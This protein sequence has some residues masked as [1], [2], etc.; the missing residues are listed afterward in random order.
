MGLCEVPSPSQPD[1]SVRG[2]SGVA[3]NI[4]RVRAQVLVWDH[5]PFLARPHQQLAYPFTKS[6]SLQIESVQQ[7]VLFEAGAAL[8]KPR[9]ILHDMFVAT[10]RVSVTENEDGEKS[11]N[12]VYDFVGSIESGVGSVAKS[13][14]PESV[15]GD[16]FE[17]KCNGRKAKRTITLIPPSTK[18]E[19]TDEIENPRIG[20]DIFP[21]Q[22]W[23]HFGSLFRQGVPLHPSEYKKSMSALE[24]LLTFTALALLGAPAD[25]CPRVGWNLSDLQ[26][27][28]KWDYNTI[29]D[30]DGTF[31]VV[32]P[33]QIMKPAENSATP[34]HWSLE[35]LTPTWQGEDFIV[36]V[37][38]GDKEHPT[39]EDKNPETDCVDTTWDDYKY[40][41]YRLKNP[42]AGWVDGIS[43]AAFYIEDKKEET[44]GSTTSGA[45]GTG[46]QQANEENVDVR[47]QVYWWKYKTYIL[48]EIGAGHNFH[49]YFIEIVKGRNPR[50]LHIGHVWDNPKR[51]QAGAEGL[52]PND[53]TW[54]RQC[55]V[56]SEYDNVS[57]DEL[58]KK[59]DFRFTVRNHLGKMVITFEGYE[60]DPWV[61]TRLDN[62]PSRFNFTQILVPMIVPPAKMRMHGG[63]ISAT[64]NWSPLEYTSTAVIPY[65]DRQ[66]DTGEANNNDLYMT[67]SHMGVSIQNQNTAVKRRFFSEKRLG[68]GKIGYDCDAFTVIECNKNAFKN[69]NLYD[70]YNR[71]FRLYGKGWVS[72]KPVAGTSEQG[73]VGLEKPH[74]LIS[75]LI[76]PHVLEILNLRGRNRSSSAPFRFGL[77]EQSDSSYPYKEFVSRWDVGIRLSAGSVL[78][79][80]LSNEEANLDPGVTTSPKLFKNYVTPIA[81]QWRMIVLGGGKPIQD[82]VDVID[83]SDLIASINDSWNAEGFTTINH[84]MEVEAYIP[85]GIPVGGDPAQQS[86][87]KRPDLHA[88]GQKLLKL[89]DKAFY[90]TVSYWWE[91]G[92]GRRDAIG[93]TLSRS[94][95]P[96]SSDLLIQMT[97]V[98]YGATL[99]RSVNKIFMKFAVKD[100]MSVLQKQLI[101]NSPFFDAVAD[102]DAVYELMKMAHFDDDDRKTSGIDRRPLG[103]LQKVIEESDFIGDGKFTYNG[104][105]SRS[106]R[107]D[108]PGSF[109]DLA[110]PAVRFQNGETFESAI[111]KI[112]QYASKLVYFDRWGVLRYEN[113]PAIEAAFSTGTRENFEPVYQFTTSPFNVSSSGSGTG[114]TSEERF[115]FDPTL[116][117]A[118]L[119]YNVA[120]YTRSVED[121]V[122]QIV[123]MTASNNITLADGSQV[124]GFIVEGYTFF[125]QI[126]DPNAEGFLGFRKPFYQSNGLFGGIEGVRKGIQHYAKMK[127][128]PAMINFQTYGV[129]G[130]KALDIISLDDNLFYITEITHELDPEENNWWMNISGEWLK[131]FLGDLGFLESRGSTSSDSGSGEETNGGN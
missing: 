121:C 42:P 36:T 6:A 115:I 19:C 4:G 32:S 68:F 130:L 9:K 112:A 5:D 23:I 119:V 16:G 52:D 128:P 53:F 60:G 50:F 73:E 45:A 104:E 97:G 124:G 10:R 123:L 129:P 131:P 20:K 27:A 7:S 109:A 127:F 78:M 54:V 125:E 77:D 48:V 95:P 8:L 65:L 63:N 49:N 33:T 43:N 91:A 106:R 72:D 22:V 18:I 64:I 80:V 114:T 88:L 41:M 71:Q 12:V 100:Y 28:I 31:K 122:N 93:N 44:S 25:E 126:W 76:E 62:D 21:H 39:V 3:G 84:E 47:R 66:A 30:S 110:N 113:I 92:V 46:G 101:F 56:L 94:G 70:F 40:L 67:F 111:K 98:A 38:R 59:K 58:F 85:L 82:N 15:S 83:V 96:E 79:P 108:L 55:R 26:N 118:H 99:E 107:F 51:L 1:Y 117:A 34:G 75:G 81:T 86:Q 29:E 14:L 103:Y 13:R 61:I 2:I 89:N 57:C 105:T 90:V 11:S 35:K 120:S 74:E 24:A 37:I 17:Y 69:I 116:H 87:A 102:T